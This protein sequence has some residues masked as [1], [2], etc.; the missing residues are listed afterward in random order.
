MQNPEQFVLLVNASILGCAYFLV[1]P[2][3]AG[4][5][6]NRLAM[7]DL[8]ASGISLA[9]VGV[10]Y[11]GSGE[12]FDLLL[13]EVGWFGFTLLTFLLMELPL[14]VW[15]ARRYKVFERTG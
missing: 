11:W 8:I 7:N 12:R 4:A 13:F 6:L 9:V 3:F 5:D 10:S 14:F 15:Y 2:R 1:Y